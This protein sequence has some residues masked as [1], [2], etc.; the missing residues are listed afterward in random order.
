[1]RAR[2]ELSRRNRGL[3]EGGYDCVDRVVL[4][5]YMSICHSPGG[6]RVWWRAWHDGRDDTLDDAHLI[7]LAGRFARRVRAVAAVRGIPVIDCEPGQR[8]HLI[9]EEYLASRDIDRGLFLILVAKAV[10]PT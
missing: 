8:K 4:N 1:M 6:F 2:D 5:A 10:A 3:L 9:A 7:R